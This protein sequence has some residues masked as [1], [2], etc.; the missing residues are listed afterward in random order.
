MLRA[1]LAFCFLACANA[2]VVPARAG[3]ITMASPGGKP[4][5]LSP[6]SNYPTTKNIQKQ[7]YGFGSFV[8]AFQVPGKKEKYGVPI[9]LPNGNINPAYLAAERKDM[10]DQAKKNIAATEAK[11]KKLISNKQF[12]L[13]DFIRKK[14]GEVGSGKDYYESGR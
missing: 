1:V 12:E 7:S 4:K 2:L 13:A 6:G 10:A 3:A 14:I 11:R 8:Q 9:Y 5:P